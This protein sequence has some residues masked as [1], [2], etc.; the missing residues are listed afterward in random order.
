MG[1]QAAGQKRDPTKRRKF[2]KHT[3]NEF[4]ESEVR[5]PSEETSLE[6]NRETFRHL[7]GWPFVFIPA[8]T[9]ILGSD[10]NFLF[11]LLLI[12]VFALCHVGMVWMGGQEALIS[13]DDKRPLWKLTCMLIVIYF[14]IALPALMELSCVVY[15]VGASI[16]PIPTIFA[17]DLDDILLLFTQSGCFLW[18]A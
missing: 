5:K 11:T 15:T 13:P 12:F 17:S 9:I 7:M 3:F 8:A 10:V 16:Q 18:R 6:I 2:A 14:F 1:K 4:E